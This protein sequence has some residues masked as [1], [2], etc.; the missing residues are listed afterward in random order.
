MLAGWKKNG[1]LGLK[2]LIKKNLALHNTDRLQRICSV[3]MV[4]TDFSVD[5]TLLMTDYCSV[6]IYTYTDWRHSI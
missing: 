2:I 3:Y 4:V 1:L 5:V 6:V